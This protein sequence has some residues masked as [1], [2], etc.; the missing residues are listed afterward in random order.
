MWECFPWRSSFL[1]REKHAMHALPRLLTIQLLKA[2]LQPCHRKTCPGAEYVHHIWWYPYQYSIFLEHESLENYQK[3]MKTMHI[4]LSVLYYLYCKKETESHQ[5]GHSGWRSP[6]FDNWNTEKVWKG[7]YSMQNVSIYT[8]K[9][10]M[11]FCSTDSVFDLKWWQSGSIPDYVLGFFTR[12][13]NDGHRVHASG[14]NHQN[15]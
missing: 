9:Y 8:W 1:F 4:S 15:W 3:C 6:D 14:K 11:K 5:A 10:C 7:L 2:R 13:G 12:L